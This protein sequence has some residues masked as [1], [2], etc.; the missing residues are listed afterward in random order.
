MANLNIELG[1]EFIDRVKS[2]AVRNYGDSGDAFMGRVIESA[3]EM[4][5]LSIKLVKGGGN[6]I[7]EPI[8]GWELSLGRFEVNES[9]VSAK[10]RADAFRVAK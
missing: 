2:L 10:S 8:T 4:R 6:E 9:V 7:E 1:N 3:L 5:L